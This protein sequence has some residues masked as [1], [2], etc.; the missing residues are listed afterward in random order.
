MSSKLLLSVTLNIV[1]LIAAATFVVMALYFHS[2][3]INPQ[4]DFSRSYNAIKELSTLNIEADVP[5]KSFTG[6]TVDSI[7]L[8]TEN[9]MLMVR[10]THQLSHQDI[11]EVPMPIT[12]ENDQ[13][14]SSHFEHPYLYR[15]FGNHSLILRTNITNSISQYYRTPSV[16]IKQA[17]LD[18][19]HFHI[20]GFSRYSPHPLVLQVITDNT[21]SIFTKELPLSDPLPNAYLFGNEGM[22]HPYKNSGITLHVPFFQTHLSKLDP[23]SNSRHTFPSIVPTSYA[24]SIKGQF[25]RSGHYTSSSPKRAIQLLSYLANGVL[26]VQSNVPSSQDTYTLFKNH[27]IIDAYDVAKE[28]YLTSYRIPKQTTGSIPFIVY[29][30][31]IYILQN[32]QVTAYELLP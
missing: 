1:L 3:K 5:V 30:Q 6:F 12:I 20:M 14:F 32:Q 2:R 17:I 29:N 25:K 4:E 31:T 10:M 19:N 23:M 21:D 13:L 9:T 16:Y 8:Q 22:L 24:Q 18:S 7:Y 15:F 11:S 28:T 27:L 26:Y